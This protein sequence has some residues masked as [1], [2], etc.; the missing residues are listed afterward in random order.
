MKLFDWFKKKPKPGEEEDYESVMHLHLMKTMT[1]QLAI[2][3]YQAIP[4][5]EFDILE[6]NGEFA[7]VPS[8]GRINEHPNAYV[9]QLDVLTLHPVYF[10]EGIEVH[11]AGLG[12]E[13]GEGIASAVN[14]YV[15]TIFPPIVESFTC[16]HQP[17]LD[18]ISTAT[19]REILWHPRPGIMSLQGTWNSMPEEDALFALLKTALQQ[20]LPDQQFNWLKLYIARQPDG[21]IIAECILN[22]VAWDLGTEIIYTYAQ[23]WPQP[24]DFLSQKQFIMFRRC[25]RYDL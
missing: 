3:Q 2:L 23:A 1:E 21:E 16:N 4:S 10:P 22:N 7:I 11:V 20:N 19:G 8:I 15:G 24:G 17:D 18:F 12:R 6:V 25:D 5:P 14:N 9:V 13:L